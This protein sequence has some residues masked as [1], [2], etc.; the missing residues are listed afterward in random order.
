MLS[1]K[2]LYLSACLFFC[3]VLASNFV[4]KLAKTSAP[5][6]EKWLSASH[7]SLCLRS[8]TA[9]DKSSCMSTSIASRRLCLTIQVVPASSV[10]SAPAILSPVSCACPGSL[11]SSHFGVSRLQVSMP[12]TRSFHLPLSS[13][14]ASLW[15]SACSS[16]LLLFRACSLLD[17]CRRSPILIFLSIQSRRCDTSSSP[18]PSSFDSIQAA[19]FS[20]LVRSSCSSKVSFSSVAS[21]SLSRGSV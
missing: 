12:L 11:P 4:K 15:P 21:P 16:C 5:S 14:V 20:S 18:G 2:R 6:C 9:L 17:S 1:A 10:S 3:H 19:S 13:S 7:A 8:A